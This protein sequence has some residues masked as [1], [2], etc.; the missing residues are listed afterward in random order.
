MIRVKVLLMCLLAMAVLP[1]TGQEGTP[2]VLKNLRSAEQLLDRDTME[3]DT[4]SILPESFVIYDTEAKSSADTSQYRL[5]W[6]NAILYITDT[7]LIGQRRTITYRVFPF[8]VTSVMANKDV[9]NIVRYS[10]DSFY[11]DPYYYEPGRITEEDKIEWGQLNYSGSFARGISIGN[12]QSLALN[13]ELDLQL[14][15]LIG[16]DVEIT[17]ALTDN[18]IPIQPDGNTAQIQDFDKVFIQVRKGKHTTIA[19]DYELEERD[20]YFMRYYKQLQGASYSGEFDILKDLSLESSISF[21]IAK[22]QFTRNTFLGQEGNQGPYRL[23]GA[24]GETF[25]IVL[26][27]SEKVYLDNELLTR[28]EDYDYVVDY[29]AGEVVFT[30]NRFITKDSRIVVE[31]EYADRNYFRSFIQTA[32][33]VK[34]KGVEAYFKLYNEQDNKN[35]PINVSLDDEDRALLAA[36]GDNTD[37][38]FI[39]GANQVEFDENRVLYALKDTMV[40]G[41]TY[42]S[43]YIFSTDETIAEYALSFTFLGLGNGNYEPDANSANGSVFKWVAPDA[44]GNP[45]G[46]Y[47]PIIL[48][49]TPKQK[50]L[51]VLGADYEINDKWTIGAEAGLSKRDVN[52]FSEEGDGDDRDVAASTYIQFKD[53][54]G[55]DDQWRFNTK[56]GYEYT[57]ARFEFIEPYRPVEFRRDWNLG[58]ADSSVREHFV[59]GETRMSHEHYELT[60]RFSTFQRSGIYRG[61]KNLV[62]FDLQKRG[63]RWKNNAS[64]LNT[65]SSTSTSLF[66]R[67]RINIEKDI[68]IRKGIVIG[69]GGMQ[70]YN[71]I[72]AIGSDSLLSPSF[73][74][75]TLSAYFRSA[76]SSAVIWKLKYDRWV[77]KEEV[78]DGFKTANVA[79]TI[80]FS[81]DVRALKSQVLKWKFTYRNLDAR[82]STLTSEQND[83]NIL[84]RLEY[85]FN[86]KNGAIRYNA[87]YELGSGQERQRDFTYLR[88][89]PGEG[90]YTWIDQNDDGFQQQNEFLVSEFSDSAS[91]VRVFSSFNEFTQSHVTKFDQSVFLNPKAVWGSKKGIKGFIARF[92]VQSS[93]LISKKSQQDEG[94]S[95][96]NPF[97][98]SS[99]A[100]NIISVNA[101]IRNALYFNRNS[102][103]YKISYIQGWSQSRILLLNGIDTRQ[104]ASHRLETKY[105]VKKF[106]SLRLDGE[107]SKELLNS[108]FFDTDDFRIIR[109]EAETGVEYTWKTKI[110]TGI[111]Y[112]YGLRRN[113]PEFGDEEA[114]VHELRYDFKFSLVGK[115]TLVADFRYVQIGYTGNSENTTKTYQLLDGLKPGTNFLWNL[116]L[117]QQLVRQL[118][119][120]FQYEGRKSGDSRIIHTGRAQ[121][122]ALF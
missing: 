117:E 7:A 61:Y 86:V 74:N 19:G 34:Y 23:T 9:G 45:T 76:D 51:M 88:V 46:S 35:N 69:L 24:N 98:L 79:H 54:V 53:E 78:R 2:F 40:N 13:S 11:F 65:Q 80:D 3:L 70:D 105:Q 6:A 60:Y 67:P 31:F 120:S 49:I 12:S 102:P 95:A 91:Y 50:Q 15:G 110:R 83:N 107:I 116:R 32:H 66:F 55:K 94:A 75:N 71:R 36:I 26:A 30:P 62:G 97:K 38:A 92:S 119:L 58:I 10:A 28:G 109:Y 25:I 103:V 84:G 27:G 18:N 16:K 72:E 8:K 82:D 68:P 22:G 115:S 73:V 96:F 101:S 39:S 104:L 85:G 5:D 21:S 20:G 42:D 56:V 17:A 87:I 14:T 59:Y 100:D 106:L 48:L 47:E 111:R 33:K 99:G 114:K 1:L 122:R 93:M 52:R 89:Q 37:E 121:I 113:A 29:N 57:G 112:E 108:E 44:S 90:I 41:T 77:D 43:I 63:W 118:Q 64:V 81:G 4:L